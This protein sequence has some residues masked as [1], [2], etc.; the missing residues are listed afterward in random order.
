MAI[1]RSSDINHTPDVRTRAILREW[2]CRITVRFPTPLMRAQSVANLLASAGEQSGAGDWRQQK[3][4]GSYGSYILVASDNPDFKRVMAEGGRKA[5]VE[6]L[7]N[8]VAYNDETSEMLAW[9]GVEFNR[10]GFK[11]VA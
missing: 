3:G 9:F 5:Q 7:Q 11:A 8:P 10:R 6:A 4:S 1:T 2:A